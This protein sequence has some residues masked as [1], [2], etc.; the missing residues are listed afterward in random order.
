MPER[1]YN[2]TQSNPLYPHIYLEIPGTEDFQRVADF[3]DGG[4]YDWTTWVAWYSPS[5]RR[6]FIASGSGCSCNS[7]SQDI[8]TIEDFTALASKEA[9]KEDL[10]TFIAGRCEGWRVAERPSIND[11]LAAINAFKPTKEER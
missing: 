2:D 11:E 6:Y 10:R 7:L 5:R 3:D 1:K 9:V 4:G 8:Y